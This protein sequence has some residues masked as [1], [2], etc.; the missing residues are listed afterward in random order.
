MRTILILLFSAFPFVSV[1]AETLNIPQDKLKNLQN[2]YR[3]LTSKIR[4]LDNL[5]QQINAGQ[6][7][8]SV[9][10]DSISRQEHVAQKSKT[11]LRSLQDFD[12]DHPGSISANQLT[13]AENEY[14]AAYQ[15]LQRSKD[16]IFDKEKENSRLVIKSEGVY[17]DIQSLRLPFERDLHQT[18]DL[19]MN[20]RLKSRQARKEITATAKIPCGEQSIQACKAR[21]VK[22]AELK[23]VEMGSVVFVSS[24]TEINNYKLTKEDL[25]SE[26]QAILTNK[27]YSNQHLVGEAEYET[28]VTANV[29]AVVGK[30][31]QKQMSDNISQDIMNELGGNIDFS[32]VQKPYGSARTDDYISNRDDEDVIGNRRVEEA[33]PPPAPV[34]TYSPAKKTFSSKPAETHSGGGES[35][36]VMSF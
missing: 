22:A 33:A 6:S 35:K 15:E 16:S 5:N 23:A 31:L 7:D 27:R 8:I 20:E 29:E 1:M 4:E 3:I 26:V 13:E 19:L 14:K 24:L 30:S 17:R 28:T 32:R 18:S 9:L 12:R 11:Q 34:K 36:S 10:K 2:Q 21:S 25:R